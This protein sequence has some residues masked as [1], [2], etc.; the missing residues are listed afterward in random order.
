MAMILHKAR[1]STKIIPTKLK[2]QQTNLSFNT[3]DTKRIYCYLQNRTLE[4]RK[5]KGKK[6]K[7]RMT[8]FTTI[9]L[10]GDEVIY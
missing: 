1:E 6:A 5:R 9:Q 10:G 8:L 2:N 3:N 7:S 4:E